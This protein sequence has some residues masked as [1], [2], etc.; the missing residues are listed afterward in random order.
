MAGG[1]FELVT[2]LNEGPGQL[3]RG[4]QCRCPSLVL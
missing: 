4:S 2:P 1:R 3:R